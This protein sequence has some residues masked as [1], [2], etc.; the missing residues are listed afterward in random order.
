MSEIQFE[1]ESGSEQKFTSRV[2]MGHLETPG[3][4]KFL[5]NHKIIKSE[6]VAGLI[7]KLIAAICFLASLVIFY[8]TLF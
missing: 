1:N 7:L 4:V 8:V 2:I 5:I 6:K 3:L